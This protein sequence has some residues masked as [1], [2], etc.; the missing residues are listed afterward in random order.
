MKNSQSAKFNGERGQGVN[1]P[2]PLA[3]DKFY[4]KVANLP[5]PLNI[6]KL[7]VFQLQEGCAPL[8]ADQRLCPWIPMGIPFP[9]PSYR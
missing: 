8:T 5:L 7:K 2:C 6:Q 9:D 3:V 4:K 1:L